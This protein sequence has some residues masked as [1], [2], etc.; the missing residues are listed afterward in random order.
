MSFAKDF[1]WGAATA[2]YQIEGGAYEG[3]KGLNGWD[4]AS[5]TPGRIF[6]GHSGDVGCDH[7]HRFREDV[8]LMK[9]LG[10]KHYRLSVNW[11]RLLPHGTGEVSEEGKRFYVSLLKELKGAG[12]TPW[13]TFFH[14]DYPYEL[15]LKGGWLN[16]ESSDW[17]A[18][19][20][21]VCAELFGDYCDR[22][23][24]INEPQCFVGLGHFAAGH[25]PFLK[26]PAAEV[27]RVAHNVLLG[28][29]KAEKLIRAALPRPVKIGTAQAYWP[30][31]PLS[32]SDIPMAKRET[33]A[34]HFDFGSINYY[35]DPLVYGRYPEEFAAWQ[36]SVG[37]TYDESDMRLIRSRLDFTGLNT[38]SGNYVQDRGGTPFYPDP[39]P[40]VAKTDMRWNVYP[41]SLY[42][43]PKFVYERYPMPI[44]YT[45]NGV[46][47]TE[48]KTLDGTIEDDCRIDFIKRY[49]RSL[50]RAAQEVPVE[51]YFY[52]SLMDNFE[53]AE[54]FSKKFG[55]IHID[56]ATGERTPKKS[57]YWYKKVIESNGEEIFK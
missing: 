53:W 55:L 4:V 2:S 57:A 34:C 22:F 12:I 19:Y 46:A 38:Y 36:K 14:W 48:W 13:I 25:A 37:F 1:A 32:E 39:A 21:R 42:Y 43:G 3:G 17:F 49:L 18:N 5:R 30:A 23:M 27:M 52:W 6:E 10:I 45:E 28:C 20:C 40:T 26:L 56:Y 41:D 47:L 15:Y 51:G 11:A 9:A 8:A 7:Y 50:H 16:P 31:L 35:L 33:F 29:G 54:G 44:I 24:L